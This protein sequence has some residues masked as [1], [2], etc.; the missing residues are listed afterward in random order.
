MPRSF[1]DR[2]AVRACISLAL[3]VRT[4]TVCHSGL[5]VVAQDL[6]ADDFTAQL[7]Q[8]VGSLIEKKI[9]EAQPRM[10]D[11]TGPVFTPLLRRALAMARRS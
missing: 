3:Q 7:S 1:C 2:P 5:T 6:S 8:I 4:T 10:P 9:Q 11:G